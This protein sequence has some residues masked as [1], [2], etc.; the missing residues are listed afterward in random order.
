M[1]WEVRE[2]RCGGQNPPNWRTREVIDE[3]WSPQGEE[4]WGPSVEVGG[5]RSS[6]NYGGRRTSGFVRIRESPG[7]QHNGRETRNDADRTVDIASSLDRTVSGLMG[8]RGMM[9]SPGL[10]P[11]FVFRRCTSCLYL[12]AGV[13]GPFA[14]VRA[15][16]IYTY[17]SPLVFVGPWAHQRMSSAPRVS[18]LVLSLLAGCVQRDLRLKH[19]LLR[20]RSIHMQQR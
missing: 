5:R 8:W 2:E 13:R 3:G 9:R 6:R 4:S 10:D 15:N 11:G 7:S 17:S 14:R 19:V 1:G 16:T 20:V 12:A 18:H